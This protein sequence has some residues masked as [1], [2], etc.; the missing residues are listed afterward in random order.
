MNNSTRSEVP[1][2]IVV[3]LDVIEHLT[4][5]GQLLSELY[6]H[7]RP[8]SL[9]VLTTGDF[10]S[11]MARAMGKQWRLMTPPQHLWYFTTDAMTRLTD[12][13]WVSS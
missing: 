3:M 1:F 8:G 10:G 11:I 9:L 7:T 2:D 13:I 12:T 4:N 6:S 5:P